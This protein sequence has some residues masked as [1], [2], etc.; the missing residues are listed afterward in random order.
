MAK[1]KKSEDTLGG[2]TWLL[3]PERLEY[4]NK[5]VE[6]MKA[7]AFEKMGTESLKDCMQIFNEKDFWGGD[8]AFVRPYVVDDDSGVLT[9]PVDGTLM[10]GA[11][12]IRIPGFLTGHDYIK[13]AVKRGMADEKVKAIAFN[14]NSPGGSVLGNFELADFI[15]KQRGKK[16]MMS[17]VEG[18]CCSGA[19]S[20]ASATD[21]IAMSVGS[22]AGSVGVYTMHV[23]ESERLKKAG[24]KVKFISAGATKTDGNPYEGLSTEAEKS[25]KD[26]IDGLYSNFVLRVAT[27]RGI[28]EEAVIKLG[29]RV[30]NANKS[31]E[32]GFADKT[33][34]LD[35]IRAEFI[36]NLTTKKKD[37]K[38]TK[39]AED[40]IAIADH[41][42]KV[43]AARTEAHAEGVEVGKKEMQ[44]RYAAVMGS[45]E[46]AGREEQALNMLASEDF[47]GVATPA[48]IKALGAG[49][50]ESV[51]TAAADAD[52]D[53][54]GDDSHGLKKAMK[55]EKA[56]KVSADKPEE[57]DT[58]AG[59]NDDALADEMVNLIQ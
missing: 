41:E 37:E 30:F 58:G 8:I 56:P 10:G 35:E 43:E 20:I 14:I 40:T 12:N 21:S 6:K 18:L 7:W 32:V 25:I 27:N 51:E 9:I 36:E 19:Y 24:V 47:A 46:Y 34:D 42:K 31:I 54:D 22:E 11:V 15:A 59:E 1:S 2:Q 52:A 23:D 45:A 44:E 16:P 13:M 17:F 57:H 38:M 33:G 50:K 49:A 4:I 5:D 3:P 53:K 55:T 29:A 48:L 39:P 26:R 28:S